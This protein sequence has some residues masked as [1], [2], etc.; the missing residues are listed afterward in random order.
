MISTRPSWAC[1]S[2]M[3]QSEH[4]SSILLVRQTVPAAQLFRVGCCTGPRLVRIVGEVRR[5][6]GHRRSMVSAQRIAQSGSFP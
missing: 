4:G 5:K 6:R 2:T 1:Q 3:R